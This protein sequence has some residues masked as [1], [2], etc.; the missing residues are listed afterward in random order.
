[1]RGLALGQRSAVA[2]CGRRRKV[3]GAAAEA[4]VAAVDPGHLEQDA[5]AGHSAILER[6]L[7]VQ[8]QLVPWEQR[9]RAAAGRAARVVEAA[10]QRGDAA[11]RGC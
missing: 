4:V 5:A 1:M 8:L 9:V 7:V 2:A 6:H 11:G 10:N 3:R